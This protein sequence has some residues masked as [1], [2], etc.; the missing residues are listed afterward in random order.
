VRLADPAQAK[1]LP[2]RIE[3]RKTDRLDARWLCVLLAKEM[4]PESSLPPAGD[5]GAARPDEVAQGA[6]GG[7]HPLE[8][9]ESELRALDTELRRFAQADRRCIALQTI[10]GVGPIL[11]LSPARRARRSSAADRRRAVA[12]MPRHQRRRISA[13]RAG[14][15][16][17]RHDDE[18]ERRRQAARHRLPV[19]VQRT[20]RVSPSSPH[21]ARSP[22]RQCFC[23]GKQAL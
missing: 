1:A 4:L 2:G 9:V 6:G 13:P 7:S 23:C 5:P 15:A 8:A 22:A 20:K 11:A 16:A 10:Y 3:R 21:A 12:R 19:I 14:A 17:H 18:R